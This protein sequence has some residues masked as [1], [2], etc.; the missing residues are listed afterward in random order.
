MHV[1]VKFITVLLFSGLFMAEAGA[2]SAESDA[3]FNAAFVPDERLNVAFTP[4]E[5]ETLYNKDPKEID[6]LNYCIEHATYLGFWEPGEKDANLDGTVS[7]E[8]S[9]TDNFFELGLEIK[10]YKFQ[11]FRIEGVD[12]KVLVVQSRNVLES[13]MMGGKQ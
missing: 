11:Y 8:Q 7:L 2:Q 1:F 9:K 6:F 10:D 3:S 5:L 12:D 13:Q 4:D